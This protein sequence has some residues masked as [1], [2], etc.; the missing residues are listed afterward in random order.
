MTEAIY[1][2]QLTIEVET[3]DNFVFYAKFLTWLLS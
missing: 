3:I 2:E 1:E